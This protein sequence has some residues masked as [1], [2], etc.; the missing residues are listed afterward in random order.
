MNPDR[1]NDIGLRIYTSS[2][3]KLNR[4]EIDSLAVKE[5]RTVGN[6]VYKK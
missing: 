4:T 2:K 1:V 5:I 3:T 6:N